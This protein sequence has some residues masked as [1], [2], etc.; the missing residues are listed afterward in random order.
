MVVLPYFRAQQQTVAELPE[1]WGVRYEYIEVLA[2]EFRIH[3]GVRS[4]HYEPFVTETV[5]VFAEFIALDASV[6]KLPI[7]EAYV[8]GVVLDE[9]KRIESAHRPAMY[10]VFV[11]SAQESGI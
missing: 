4:K 5:D 2:V 11:P 1:R 10:A 7:D 9:F 3:G 8:F 6:V